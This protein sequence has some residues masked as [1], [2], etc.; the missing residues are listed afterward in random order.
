MAPSLTLNRSPA[1][2]RRPPPRQGEHTREVLTEIGFDDAGIENLLA[3]G[4]AIAE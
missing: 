1:S 3:S 2:I 4:A